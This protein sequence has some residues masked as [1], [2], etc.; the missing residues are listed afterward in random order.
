MWSF[1]RNA[2]IKQYNNSSTDLFHKEP[3]FPHIISQIQPQISP[4][5]L[6]TKTAMKLIPVCHE[7]NVVIRNHGFETKF[8]KYVSLGIMSTSCVHQ[9]HIQSSDAAYY[10][11]SIYTMIYD[12]F[13][14][15][16]VMCL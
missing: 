5:Y 3:S 12:Y 8:V 6:C 7:I 13:V 14:C 10:V 15:I 9:F 1:I 4:S 16:S 2:E 11:N